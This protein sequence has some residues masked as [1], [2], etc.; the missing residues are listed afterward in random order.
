[1]VVCVKEGEVAKVFELWGDSGIM[2]VGNV[3]LVDWGM[4]GVTW[5]EGFFST[6]AV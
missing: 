1:M 3:G 4:E 5:K 2:G 6:R